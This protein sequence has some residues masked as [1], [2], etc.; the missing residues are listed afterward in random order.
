MAAFPLST[1]PPGTAAAMEVDTPQP[2]SAAARIATAAIV[3]SI[4]ITILRALHPFGEDPK[5]RDG[6][7]HAGW[8][9]H[10]EAA[11]L[12]VFERGESPGRGGRSVGRVPDLRREREQRP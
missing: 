9:P 12:L 3:H 7:Q 2:E 5:A 4:R 10:D 6:V 8:D 1:S 11:E